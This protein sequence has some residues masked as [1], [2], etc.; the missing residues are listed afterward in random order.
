EE[1]RVPGL[2]L[3]LAGQEHP[4]V[5]R[6]AEQ[7]RRELHLDL[8]L[9]VVEAGRY[10]Q[11]RIARVVGHALGPVRPVPGEVQIVD[12]PALPKVAVVEL[13]VPGKAR[14]RDMHVLEHVVDVGPPQPAEV[15]VLDADALQLPV[16]D[17]HATLPP[18]PASAPNPRQITWFVMLTTIRPTS[19]ARRRWIARVAG[20]VLAP[21]R[22][23]AGLYSP[24]RPSPERCAYVR[25]NGIREWRGQWRRLRGR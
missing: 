8:A 6:H 10:G 2:V 5:L 24:R 14:G 15:G 11:E 19:Q 25:P 9:A 3:E 12:V 4:V 13:S 16:G 20:P 22:A 21:G 7:Q 17:S 1:H 23:R 18:A